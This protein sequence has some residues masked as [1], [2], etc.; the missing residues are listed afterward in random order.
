ML[1]QLL[2]KSHDDL[3]PAEL[4]FKFGSREDER[5]RPA[6]RAMMRIRRQMPSLQQRL[7]LGRRKR[8]PSLH[9][10][11]TRDHT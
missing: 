1:I 6:V 11:L 10:G 3:G 8:I 7:D 2:L 9:G 5:R 4:P